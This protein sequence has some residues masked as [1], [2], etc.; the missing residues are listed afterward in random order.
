MADGDTGRNLVISLHPLK[1][2]TRSIDNL[3]EA[4]LMSARGNSGNIAVEFFHGLLTSSPE[5]IFLEQ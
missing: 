3:I 1:D 5:K 4:L 2:E